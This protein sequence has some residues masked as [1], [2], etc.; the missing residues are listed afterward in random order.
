MLF[1]II[2][3]I[4]KMTADANVATLVCK[5]GG[6][7]NAKTGLCS[8]PSCYT[9]A[10]CQNYDPCCSFQCKNGGTKIRDGRSCICLCR[11]CY[12]GTFCQ[13]KGTQCWKNLDCLNGGMFILYRLEHTLALR[14]LCLF[15]SIFNVSIFFENYVFITV[16]FYSF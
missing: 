3:I 14:S 16:L 1:I 4:G 7:I 10:T 15:F 13:N 9:G 12:L 2:A 5:N 6:S 8:C 11:A